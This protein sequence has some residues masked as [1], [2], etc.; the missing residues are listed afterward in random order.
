MQNI[1][2]GGMYDRDD[3]LEENPRAKTLIELNKYIISIDSQDD[4]P[5]LEENPIKLYMTSFSPGFYLQRPYIYFYLNRDQAENLREIMD[6]V[7]DYLYIGRAGGEKGVPQKTRNKAA[8]EAKIR[9]INFLIDPANMQELL[10]EGEKVWST[11]VDKGKKQFKTISSMPS[12]NRNWEEMHQE[13]MPHFVPV[14]IESSR[15]PAL[16][17]EDDLVSRLLKLVK[18]LD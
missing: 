11:E 15:L 14:R 8:S 13:M 3:I 6:K 5:Q 4:S 17:V 18:S 9:S 12:I 2:S 10:T 1:F 7:P 16:G